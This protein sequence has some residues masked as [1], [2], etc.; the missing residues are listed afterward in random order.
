[1]AIALVA[2]ASTLVA[3]APAGAGNAFPYE[4]DTGRE[5]A[6]TGTGVVLLG[7][8]WAIDRAGTSLTPEEIALLERNMVPGIDRG[9][10]RRWS[11]GAAT[12]SDFLKFAT[13]ASP[14]AL[15][16]TD[17]GGKEPWVL[18]T[19]YGETLLLTNGVVGMMKV[20]F[21]RTRP[22]V[23][24]DDPAIPWSLKQSRFARRSF[25]S[26]HTANAFAGSVFLSVTY[27]RLYPESQ[28]SGWIW[29]GSLA[30]A[31]TVGYLRYAAGRHF[32]TDIVAGAA[33]GALFG[34]LV[35]ELHEIDPESGTEAS[36][37]PLMV[38][39]FSF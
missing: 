26:G 23:Y 4:L 33:I 5:L 15:L 24:N 20:L 21:G 11:T 25:P 19:M 8:A 36:P 9:A 12:G 31:S 1:V 14:L 27:D 2:L 39:S 37:P 17:R 35:P 38:F 10:T 29:A 30:A 3:A 13:V 7:G 22:F 16:L 32:P 34:W 18:A 28:A 6:L